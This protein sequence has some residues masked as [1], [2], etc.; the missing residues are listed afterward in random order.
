M[1]DF[2]GSHVSQVDDHG[3]RQNIDG[4]YM[5]TSV[6]GSFRIR[7]YDNVDRI[8]VD[9]DGPPSGGRAS[10]Q[11]TMDQ[12]ELLRELLEAGIADMRAAKVIELPAGGDAA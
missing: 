6:H 1:R 4:I 11:L 10:M 9:I 8:C 2:M 5:T 3:S 12:A 7:Y